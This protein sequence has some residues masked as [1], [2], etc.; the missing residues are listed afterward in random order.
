MEHPDMLHL[1]TSTFNDAPNNTIFEI[2]KIPLV[3][4][5]RMYQLIV[6]RECLACTGVLNSNMDSLQL[7]D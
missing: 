3:Q 1:P 2:G 7:Q 6:L 5:I 4:V